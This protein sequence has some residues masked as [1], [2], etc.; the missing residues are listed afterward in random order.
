MDLVHGNHH[1]TFCVGPAQEDYDFHTGLLGLR[2]IKKT[3]LYDGEAPIYHLYYGDANGDEGTILTAFPFRQAGVMGRRGSNQIKRLNLSVPSDSLGYWADRFSAAGAAHK[4]VE[5][6]GLARLHFAHPCGIEYSLVGDDDDTG[7]VPFDGN[8]VPTDHAI[9]GTHG[10]TVSVHTEV[11]EMADF[12]TTGMGGRHIGTDG[13]SERFEIGDTGRG[14]WIELVHEP[15]LAPG[16]WRFGEGTVHHAAFDVSNLDSQV[17][18]KGFLE[19]LGYTDTSDVKDRGY[20]WSIYVR[21]PSGALFEFAWSK[22]EGWAI[23]EAPEHLGEKFQLPPQFEH[24]REEI[25][26]ALEPIE[27]EKV[28][29]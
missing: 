17:Q 19:G 10:I 25:M 3:V 12:I 28:A 6:F 4:E 13:A 23:D 7:S 27:T 21:T 14:R 5:T 26:G 22:P 9:R 18:L 2:S 29:G 20:F 24:R 1:L 16:T 15:D 11:D 8:G